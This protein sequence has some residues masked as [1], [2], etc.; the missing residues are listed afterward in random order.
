[1]VAWLLERGADPNKSGRAVGHAAGPGHGRRGMPRSK[2]ICCKQGHS[3]AQA[4]HFTPSH[5][6][7][8]FETACVP[9]N[10]VH[11]AD[12]NVTER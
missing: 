1:M 5:S 7:P 9:L 4:L 12:N 10:A 2:L 11:N 8:G 3:S 6:H